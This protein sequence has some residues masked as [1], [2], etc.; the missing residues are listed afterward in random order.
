MRAFRRRRPGCRWPDDFPHENVVNLEAD[1]RSILSLYKA[2][3]GLRKK[4]PQLVTGDY[5]PIAAQGD[6][7][8]YRR[9]SEGK[10]VVDRAESRRRAG[11]DRVECRRAQPA[12]S[13]S[14]PSWTGKGEK[15]QG[16]LDLR[17]NEGVIIGDCRCSRRMTGLAGGDRCRCRCASADSRGRRRGTSDSRRLRSAAGACRARRPGC[18]LPPAD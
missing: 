18:G 10:A 17:G 7:L 6:L 1:A 2:L 4:L 12:K 3:I 13:C 5:V 15:I 11:L 14:R 16:A 9:Q 8:L